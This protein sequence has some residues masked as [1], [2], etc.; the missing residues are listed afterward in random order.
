MPD[1]AVAVNLLWCVPGDVGGSEEYLVRQLRGLAEAEPDLRPDLYVVDGFRAAHPQLA[2]LF[3]TIVGP[4]DGASRMR[5]IAGEMTWFRRKTRSADLRHHGG[6]VAPLG[7]SRPY[8][9][10]IHDLQYRTFPGHFS[11]TKRTYLTTMIGRSVRRARVVTV[12]SEYVRTSVIE[13]CRTEPSRVMVVPHGFEPELLSDITPA[14]D[15]R[16]RYALGDRPVIVYPAVTHPHKNHQFL[17]DLL[18]TKWN[19]ADQLLVLIGGSG[20]AEGVVR[21]AADPRIR[22]LG[23]VSAADRNGLLKMA[24]AMVFPSRYEGFGAPLIE[25]MALGCPVVASD[26]TCIPA[27]VEDAGLVLPLTI[28]AWSDALERVRRDRSTMIAAGLV[29][30]QAFTARASGAA[31]AAAYAAALE[32]S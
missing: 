6:G 26:S 16:D 1:A 23:R 31:L 25:A 21:S 7:A 17:I 30:A 5:R 10:T 2:D 28:D 19:D 12:P 20:A 4:F 14:D 22:R 3:H 18:S 32:Q 15:L 11:R 27:I 8:V 13:A 24:E 9:L 29:R